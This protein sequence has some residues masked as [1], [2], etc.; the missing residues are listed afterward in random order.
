MPHITL[1][2]EQANV[3]AQ[4]GAAVE[5]RDPNGNWLGRIDPR[6]SALVADV[7]RRRGEPRKCLPAGRSRRAPARP[8]CGMGA[9]RWV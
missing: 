1:S 4:A 6:E 7:L 3:I 5:I 9:Y 2:E 8:N